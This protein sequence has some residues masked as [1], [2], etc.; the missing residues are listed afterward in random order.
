MTIL[1]SVLKK[2]DL[3]KQSKLKKV[4]G[5]SLLEMVVSLGI[6][7]V[8]MVMLTNILII[9]LQISSKT[10]ARGNVREEISDQLSNIKRDIRNAE[11][12]GNCSGENELATCDVIVLTGKF[13]WRLCQNENGTNAICKY[14]EGDNIVESTADFL[15]VDEFSFDVGFSDTPDKQT[16]V[17]TIVG[18]HVNESTNVV[19]VIQ[20]TSISTRNYAIVEPSKI[21]IPDAGPVCGDGVA[22]NPED[23]D[24]GNEIDGD[25]CSSSCM[26]EIICGDGEAEGTEECDDGNTADGDGCSSSC[27]FEDAIDPV[28]G[29]GIVEDPEECDDGNTNRY[30]GC[31]NVCTNESRRCWGSFCFYF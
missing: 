30:D 2:F 25:G 8:M 22:Q 1:L 16:I 24:D 21:A 31:S 10:A 19:N 5:F 4:S 9:S 28:C 14:D 7:A 12:V 13:T 6:I 23:C 20:Q 27:T 26:S 11:I 15:S 18:S 17:V 29:N 3:T